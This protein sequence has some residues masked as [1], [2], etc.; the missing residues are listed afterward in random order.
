MI[1]RIAQI[2]EVYASKP[3]VEVKQVVLIIGPCPAGY[4]QHDT[5]IA[6]YHLCARLFSDSRYDEGQTV[7]LNDGELE[8]WYH[9]IS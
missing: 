3:A 8:Q 2:G 7:V 5:D 6:Y 4:L 9:R 1:E